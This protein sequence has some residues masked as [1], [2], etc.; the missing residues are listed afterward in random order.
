MVYE[1]D[2]MHCPLIISR[3]LVTAVFDFFQ[4]CDVIFYFTWRNVRK[5]SE[6]DPSKEATVLDG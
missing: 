2:T 1:H 4:V 3:P 5:S 6:L